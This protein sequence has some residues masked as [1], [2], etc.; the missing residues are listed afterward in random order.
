MKI[1]SILNF[2]NDKK[3]ILKTIIDNMIKT[4][5]ESEVY[6]KPY[7][8]PGGLISK[9]YAGGILRVDLKKLFPDSKKGDFV[10]FK[11]NVYTTC[12][13][14]ISVCVSGDA[15]VYYRGELIAESRSDR[16]S[17]SNAKT[18]SGEN[19][20]IIKVYA[21][22]SDFE[23]SLAVSP[24]P[25]PGNWSNDY[26]M[27]NRIT[28]PVYDFSGE[29]GFIISPLMTSDNDKWNGE[30]RVYPSEEKND[31]IID[32]SDLYGIHKDKYAIALSFCKSEGK[33]EIECSRNT[34]IYVNGMLADYGYVLKPGDRIAVVSKCDENGWG[35]KS[36]CNDI[37]DVRQ[38]T[39]TNRKYAHWLILG[40]FDD[41]SNKDKIVFDDVYFNSDGKRTFWRFAE[42]N[43][44]L[45][46]YL[47]TCF[48]GQWYYALMV[49]H[50]G[51]LNAA[52]VLGDK[53]LEYFKKS[54][55]V[56]VTYFDYMRYEK[57]IFAEPSFLSKSWYLDN[58]DSI[59]SIGMNLCEYYE[60]TGDKK[61]VD[62]IKLL[63]QSINENIP[64]SK[65]GLY[66]RHPSRICDGTVKHTM[67]ADDAYM[68]CPF[69]VRLGKVLNDD[70]YYD[71]AVIQLEG[72][73]N[74]LYM[75]NEMLLSHVYFVDEDVQCGVPWG[76]GN[77]WMF[78][79]LADVMERLPKEYKAKER[80]MP[81]YN[82]L[83]TGVMNCA[84]GGMWH[85]VLNDFD[86]YKETSCTAMFIAGIAKGVKNGWIDREKYT[87]F[88]NEACREM[89]EHAVDENGCI[90]GVC[91]GSGCHWDAEYYKNLGTVVNDD[92][93]TGIVLTALCEILSL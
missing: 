60:I 48:F 62:I 88:V 73:F 90:Y 81:L 35:F 78:Y 91:K 13:H 71:E 6:L 82:K 80:L 12:R 75:E 50:Y 32:F 53:Y 89:L 23:F 34:Q 46:P 85:Q 40:Y 55:S 2:T 45:R 59:G 33:L 25:F 19:E 65:D 39:K 56:L 69:F 21:N 68:S 61:A 83:L 57:D 15:D 17:V 77:G 42:K 37:L 64:K 18:E 58:F 51:I 10:Y 27:W 20:L 70:R 79:S 1:N 72:L 8:N 49:G 14:D 4:R 67:W 7:Y 44:Y 26:L 29:E 30:D 11:T 41:D 28:S 24:P 3:E 87:A 86:S 52:E 93:G 9:N 63:A 66:Y 38:I 36:H 47:N 92:H 16:L 31:D 43:T 76:R 74:K 84:D 54:M 22:D 5:P